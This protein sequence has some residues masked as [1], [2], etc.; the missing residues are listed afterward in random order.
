M[1]LVI[2]SVLIFKLNKAKII[3]QQLQ[4]K[5]NIPQMHFNFNKYLH[6]LLKIKCVKVATKYTIYH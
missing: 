6:I 2:L 3:L 5:I 1:Y 4:T